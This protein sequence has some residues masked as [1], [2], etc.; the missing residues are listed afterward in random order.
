M[1][2]LQ[3][4]GNQLSLS[5]QPSSAS[6]IGTEGEISSSTLLYPIRALP[7]KGADE[8]RLAALIDPVLEQLNSILIPRR[9]T[10][11]R[12]VRQAFENVVGICRDVFVRPQVEREVHRKAVLL[13]KQDTDV[14]AE[15]RHCAE[16]ERIAERSVNRHVVRLERVDHDAPERPEGDHGGHLDHLLLAVPRLEPLKQLV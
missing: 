6:E 15:A 16:S 7:L 13:T 1:S 3:A 8:L 10:R 5:D 9:V 11:H 12:A 2:V 14:F 4:P